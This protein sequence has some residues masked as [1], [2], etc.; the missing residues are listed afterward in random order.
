M[1][2]YEASIGCDLCKSERVAGSVTESAIEAR[3]SAINTAAHKGWRVYIEMTGTVTT[4]WC[5]TCIS[6]AT[7][8]E[9]PG[10]D[11]Q[12]NGER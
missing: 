7:V 9:I 5:P 12:A 10:K 11:K 4:A 8:H 1:I 2:S 6:K 3:R